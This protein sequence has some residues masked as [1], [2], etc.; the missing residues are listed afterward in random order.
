MVDNISDLMHRELNLTNND[1]TNA[2]NN[3]SSGRLLHSKVLLS[4]N[5]SDHSSSNNTKHSQHQHAFQQPPPIP[6][7][8]ATSDYA[9]SSSLQASIR[10]RYPN[11]QSMPSGYD[12]DGGTTKS[13][14]TQKHFHRT[15][16]GYE[17]LVS[18]R[19]TSKRLVLTPQSQQLLTVP[20][21]QNLAQ[22]N[23][24]TIKPSS[25][26]IQYYENEDEEPNSANDASRR[27]VRPNRRNIESSPTTERHHVNNN[28]SP[29]MSRHERV[30]ARTTSG[31][32][33]KLIFM[34]HSER[35]NQ[36][37]GSDW[38]IKAFRTNTY[39]AYD[40][41]LP[42]VLPKRRFDQAYEFDTPLTGLKIILVFFLYC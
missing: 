17:H 25:G 30:L 27:H 28:L 42:M 38:F 32:P 29:I 11:H 39:R 12:T 35:A 15:N 24:L 1:A 3:A 33:L 8:I 14:S 7:I 10:R 26:M 9:N 20:G 31:K 22:E 6:T 36:A 41:N 5:M 23:Y 19:L 34:R 13:K 16:N 4:R 18:P 2:N 37:L 21:Q 40:Q